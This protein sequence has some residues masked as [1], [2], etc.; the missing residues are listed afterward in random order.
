MLATQ[1]ALRCAVRLCCDGFEPGGALCGARRDAWRDAWRDAPAASSSRARTPRRRGK[2][3]PPTARA[4]RRRVRTPS[5]CALTAAELAASA[6]PHGRNC[7]LPQGP[8]RLG[9]LVPSAPRSLEPGL[10]NPRRPEPA[11]SGATRTVAFNLLVGGPLSKKGSSF[12]AASAAHGGSGASRFRWR[13]AGVS[14]QPAAVTACDSHSPALLRRRRV[15]AAGCRLQAA[16]SSG[17]CCV[18]QQSAPQAS[19]ARPVIGPGWRWRA[20]GG[21]GG[22]QAVGALCA[23]CLASCCRSC[24]SELAIQPARV[25]RRR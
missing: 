7:S 8:E 4:R 23:A 13:C 20:G 1:C 16:G 9:G 2:T 18:G 11:C 21:Q 5:A 17:A 6:G 3:G 12:D 22:G 15:R 10:A 24:A 25:D 14:A 19:Y